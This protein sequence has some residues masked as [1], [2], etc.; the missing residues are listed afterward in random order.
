MTMLVKPVTGA[1]RKVTTPEGHI[2]KSIE[3]I[4]DGGNYI[5]CGAEPLNREQSTHLL[6][7][8]SFEERYI[9]VMF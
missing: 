1:I 7:S 5:C 3:E 4:V 2:V 6:F 9:D 8:H